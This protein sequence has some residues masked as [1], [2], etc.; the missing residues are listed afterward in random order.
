MAK[1]KYQ[2]KEFD[3]IKSLA[4]FTG[5]KAATLQYRLAK[6]CSVQEAAETPVKDITRK[7]FYQGKMYPSVEQMCGALGLD[8]GRIYARLA[9]GWSVEDAVETPVE[10]ITRRVSYQGKE[11]PSVKA[12]AEEL[13]LPYSILSHHAYRT[14][15]IEKAVEKSYESMAR[16]KPVLWGKCYAS[17][18]KIAEAYGI[19]ARALCS[20]IAQGE[21]LE[22]AVRT[23]LA[24]G[25]VQFRDKT[26][27][28]LAELCA[29]FSIQTTNVYDRLKY[30][31]TLEEAL[32][33]PIR[34]T[35]RGTK[36]SYRGK[37]YSSQ[38]SLCREYGISVGCVREQ[39]RRHR[40][41]PFLKMFDI[42]VRLKQAAG[43]PKE[44][45]LN[46]IP[47]CIVNGKLY[48]RLLDLAQELGITVSSINSHQSKHETETLFDTLRLMQ[49]K[50]VT[51]YLSDGKAVT[52]KELER[53]G[54]GCLQLFR[55][56]EQKVQ[57]PLYPSLQ[58]YDFE[59]GCYD[60]LHL[61]QQLLSEAEQEA[62]EQE[63][64]DFSEDDPQVLSM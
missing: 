39:L 16:E 14:E 19:G 35:P 10:D 40:E 13:G 43:L 53:Q 12:L 52:R 47:R 21:A 17:Y 48:K 50:T 57:V 61:Y 5:I 49:Q 29:E 31:M 42:F 64:E 20:R 24:A 45:Q 37:A 15:N 7:I 9:Y 41:I 59:T 62:E 28:G 2:G 26:Y 6:G 54:Y 30:G 60:T 63:Q 51:Q 4:E 46:F 32:T 23:L 3:S 55:M 36:I 18:E 8:A 33:K 11:Y 56:K 58:G 27:H 1:L 44:V 34:R 25:I 22:E 38:I